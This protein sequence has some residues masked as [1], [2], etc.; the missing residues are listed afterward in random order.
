[1]RRKSEVRGM[2]RTRETKSEEEQNT[3]HEERKT[4]LLPLHA[5]APFAPEVA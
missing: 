3:K 2:K 4:L 5:A 1:M